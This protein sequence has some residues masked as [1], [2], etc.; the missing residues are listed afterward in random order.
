MLVAKAAKS[1]TAAPA[2]PKQAKRPVKKYT[3][4]EYLR[5]EE[6]ASA[7]HE[8]HNGNIIPMAGGTLNHDLI[9][10]NT[11]FELRKGTDKLDQNYLILGSNI[12]IYIPDHK[13]ALYADALVICEK[14]EFWESNNLLIINPLLIVEVL[15]RSTR[16]FDRGD[17]FAFYR[18]LPSFREYVLIDQDNYQIESWYREDTALWRESH[19]TSLE[20]ELLLRSLGISLALRDVYANIAINT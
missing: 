15:S 5:K 8:F 16:T 3:L 4:Q 19:L 2:S 7:K 17:K 14:P 18:T 13:R 12:K 6:K 11:A 9:A 10:Q 20:D 1:S